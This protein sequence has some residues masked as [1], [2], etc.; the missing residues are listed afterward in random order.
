[1]I[2]EEPNDN[3]CP[4]KPYKCQICMKFYETAASLR[5]HVAAHLDLCNNVIN[6][7]EYCGFMDEEKAIKRHKLAKHTNPKFQCPICK[8][9][10]RLLKTVERHIQSTHYLSETPINNTFG[11]IRNRGRKNSIF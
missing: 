8:Q 10:F 9:T 1:M 5:H 7:C 2:K 4:V 11:G 6:I 3:K